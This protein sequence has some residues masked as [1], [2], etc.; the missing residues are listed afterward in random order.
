M[1][2]KQIPTRAREAWVGRSA[3]DIAY[4]LIIALGYGGVRHG[5]KN[6]VRNYHL[7]KATSKSEVGVGLSAR[8]SHSAFVVSL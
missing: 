3:K 7:H 8:L 6:Y 1:K 4:I 2:Q 5:G